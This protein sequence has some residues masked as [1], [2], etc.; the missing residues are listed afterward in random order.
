MK[1][2]ALQ[3]RGYNSSIYLTATKQNGH[4]E[5]HLTDYSLNDKN[6]N[7]IFSLSFKV[8]KL[9]FMY[10]LLLHNLAYSGH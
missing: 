1:Y 9:A 6:S 4:M 10:G 7:S 3:T 2:M 5:C 8:L